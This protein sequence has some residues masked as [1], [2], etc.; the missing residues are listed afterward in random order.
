[1]QHLHLAIF[2]IDDTAAELNTQLHFSY[3]VLPNLELF[4][5]GE[6]SRQ[7]CPLKNHFRVL[8]PLTRYYLPV[9]KKS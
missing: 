1:M 3:R 6:T 7:L 5:N 9:T 8:V 4:L 2:E